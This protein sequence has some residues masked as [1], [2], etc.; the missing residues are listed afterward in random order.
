VSK[1]SSPAKRTIEPEISPEDNDSDRLMTQES[2][3]LRR[4]SLGTVPPS[5]MDN[6][7]VTQPS[8]ENV[9]F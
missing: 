6:S 7:M 8:P 3:D 4:K 2:P 9:R 1:E 5:P